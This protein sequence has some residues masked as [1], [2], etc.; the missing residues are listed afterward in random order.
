MTNNYLMLN[1]DKTLVKVFWNKKSI[2]PKLDKFLEFDLNNVVKVLGVQLESGFNFNK[3]I[4]KKIKTCNMHLRNLI[5]IRESLDVST[6]ILLVSNLI[7]STL[8]YCN[9]LLL[10]CNDKELR[11]LRLI[12]NRSIRF[13][14]NVRFRAH[15]TPYYIKSHFLPIKQR[16]RFKACLMAYKIFYRMAPQYLEEKVV[17]F[18]P[19]IQNMQ[20]RE[21][22]GGRDTHMFVVNDPKEKS[23]INIIKNKWNNLALDIRRSTSINVFKTKLKSQLMSEI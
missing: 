13:I 11:P 8:D 1:E 16:I 15:I 3:F 19:N 12:I 4:A 23:L 22:T 9:V 21:G 7:L 2:S 6:R 20:L 5:N 18:T 14:Y 10:S 17:R